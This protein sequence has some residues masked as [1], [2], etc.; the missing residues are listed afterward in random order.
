MNAETTLQFKDCGK[1]I[2]PK[3]GA[4][5]WGC[6]CGMDPDEVMWEIRRWTD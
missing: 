1:C 6:T 4:V 2:Q 3:P 5:D